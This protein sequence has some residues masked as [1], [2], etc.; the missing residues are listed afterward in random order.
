MQSKQVIIFLLITVV[1][2][3][4][5]SQSFPG[6]RVRALG[7]SGLCIY[8]AWSVGNNPSV[9]PC[10]KKQTVAVASENRFMVKQLCVS[11][12]SWA[13]PTRKGGYGISYVIGGNPTCRQTQVKTAYG[14]RLGE[15]LSLGLGLN[16]LNIKY[17][18][19]YG[20]YTVLTGDIGFRA[21]LSQQL[22]IG[23][24]IHNLS[25]W[26]R[27]AYANER[28]PASME[29]G[30]QYIVSEQ[31]NTLLE[32]EKGLYSPIRIKGGLEYRAV[33]EVYIRGGLNSSPLQAAF[34]LGLRYKKW[35]IDLC[36]VYHSLLGYSPQL[37]L[38]WKPEVKDDA[39]E[40]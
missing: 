6:A 1:L 15:K 30:I 37:G 38:T 36:S 39:D 21:A 33:S 3:H 9:L 20:R 32:V 24:R 31:L 2:Q 40:K 12:L 26:Q 35:G 17:A 23:G 22:H 7:G 11:G 18:D 27:G 34:G 25:R 29:M 16:C 10:L 8:D 19:V 4:G 13:I 14:L 5:V 28:V